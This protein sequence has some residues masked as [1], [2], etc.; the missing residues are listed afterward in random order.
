MVHEEAIQHLRVKKSN[1]PNAGL[2]LFTTIDRLP[3][4]PIVGYEGKIIHNHT[5]RNNHYVLELGPNKFIDASDP[6]SGVGRYANS[7]RARDRLLT[8]NAKYTLNR[9]TNSA[10]ITAK[11]KIK[12]GS[13]IYV[14]YGRQF[15]K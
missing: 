15:W 8:N 13:E 14:S 2:G 10:N 3:S 9:R 11:K 4:R 1:I 6:N 5:D 12:K 7:V